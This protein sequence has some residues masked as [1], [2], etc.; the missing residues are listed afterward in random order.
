MQVCR[1]LLVFASFVLGAVFASTKECW[2]S[3]REFCIT[4][5]ERAIGVFTPKQKFVSPIQ[6]VPL[7]QSDRPFSP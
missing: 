5:K 2:A 7:F 6:Y 1:Y 4:V 3:G